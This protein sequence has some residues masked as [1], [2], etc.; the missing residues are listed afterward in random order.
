MEE[1]EFMREIPQIKL[2]F[3]KFLR[4]LH[5]FD[6][7][8]YILFNHSSFYTVAN[9]PEHH[10]SVVCVHFILSQHCYVCC[11]DEFSLVLNFF[12]LGNFIL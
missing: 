3:L 9:S 12:L 10:V 7:V 6:D 1:E 11:S 5:V 2:E 4:D 8:C